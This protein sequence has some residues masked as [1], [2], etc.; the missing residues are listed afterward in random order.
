MSRQMAEI[1]SNIEVMNIIPARSLRGRV[2]LPGDKSISHRAA[3]VASL[4]EGASSIRNFAESADCLS[5]LSCL[6]RL[7]VSIERNEEALL[8]R[9][10]GKRGLRMPQVPLDCGNSGTTMRL[11]SGVLAG[12]GFESELTGDESLSRRPM[13]RVIEPLTAMGA[14]F[15]SSDGFPPLRIRGTEKLNSIQYELPVASAQ[16][17]SCVL[18]AGLNARGVTSV[19]EGTP[20]RDHTERMLE[21]FG[22]GID[23]ADTADGKKISI[24]GESRLAARDLAVPAD[25]SAAAFFMVAAACLP[26]S[27]IEMTGVGLNPTRTAVLEVLLSA[28][29][30]IELRGEREESGEP[31]G[32][33]IVRGGIGSTGNV[34]G[35]LRIDGERIANLIDEIPVLAVFGT[36]IDGGV[37]VRDARELRVKES[38][39]IAAVVSNLRAMGADVTEFDDGFLVRR[40]ELNGAEID[41]FGD[42]RIAMAFAVAGLFAKGTTSIKGAGC[43]DVSFPSFFDALKGV[44]VP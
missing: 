40:S 43:I 24:S 28:G 9:G 39:R 1:R 2:R 18:L 37:E 36:Q 14:E 33:V 16:I 32:D 27:E 13:G 42:H 8:I 17:K 5:T 15:G 12:Q 19:V 6:A 20:T 23:T 35:P 34:N 38:D 44:T 29:A 7:G 41:S 25:I 21:W 10:A 4:A 31:V 11:L 22:A 26:D 3:M 30:Q